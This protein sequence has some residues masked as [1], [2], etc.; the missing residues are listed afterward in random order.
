MVGEQASSNCKA[1]RANPEVIEVLRGNRQAAIP[2]WMPHGV[3]VKNIVAED[4]EEISVT[5]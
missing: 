1:V 5:S 3:M 2:N 4:V